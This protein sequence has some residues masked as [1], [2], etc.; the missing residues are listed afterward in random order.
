M[1]SSSIPSRR[2]TSTSKRRRRTAAGLPLLATT[3]FLLLL[4]LTTT[5]T[6]ATPISDSLAQ[7]AARRYADFDGPLPPIAR[8]HPLPPT[9]RSPDAFQLTPEIEALKRQ[10]LV[11]R[12]AKHLTDDELPPLQVPESIKTSPGLIPCIY[13]MGVKIVTPVSKEF[14]NSAQSDN[15]NYHYLPLAVAY[16]NSTRQVSHCVRCAAQHGHAAVAAR[17]G[18]HSFSGS[19]SGGQDGNLVIDLGALNKV[20]LSDIGVRDAFIEPGA[21]LGDV[22]KELWTQGKRAMTHGTCPTVGVGGHALCGGFG[23]LSRAWGLAADAILHLD[24][25]LA[26]GSFALVNPVEHRELLWGMRGAGNHFAIVTRFTFRTQDVSN[27][28]LTYIEHNWADSIKGPRDFAKFLDGMTAWSSRK[29]FPAELGY[30]LQIVPTMSRDERAK[31]IVSVKLRANYIGPSQAAEM[32]FSSL[33]PELR[34]RGGE[35][36]ATP[37]RG[38]K[39]EEMTWL[40]IME[41]WD[42]FGAPGD[43]LNTAKERLEHNNYVPK[44]TLIRTNPAAPASAG[45]SVGKQIPLEAWEAWA[46]FL[47]EGAETNAGAGRWSWNVFMEMFGGHNAFHLKSEVRD[48]SSVPF[49]DGMWLIQQTVGTWP[50]SV[51]DPPGKTWVRKMHEILNTAL[52]KAQITKSSYGCYQDADLE[53]WVEEYHGKG[54]ARDRLYRLKDQYDPFNLFRGAQH[55]GSKAEREAKKAASN[56]EGGQVSWTHDIHPLPR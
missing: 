23:P 47:Y 28:N 51:V 50:G 24:V 11:Q 2:N 16:P 8:S 31:G 35:T 5:V 18:G 46:K 52:D 30:H 34:S 13:N 7:R 38:S 12:Q 44:T 10:T 1:S 29:D 4:T 14:W 20:T 41:E 56:K 53:N 26:D 43:K 32:V 37:D 42:D 33:W 6:T 48:L 54:V 25:I 17:S 49:L 19:G 36:L 15:L 40:Q 27:K 22:V 55:L 9:H 21:R 39:M 45:P 3:L